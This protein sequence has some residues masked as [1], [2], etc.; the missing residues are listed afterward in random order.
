MNHVLEHAWPL[1]QTAYTPDCC[2][3]AGAILIDVFAAYQINASPLTVRASVYNPVATTHMLE[4]GHEFE[5]PEACAAV[6]GYGIGIGSMKNDVPNNP[7]WPY[8]LVVIGEFADGRALVD[9][10]L[11]QVNRP[12]YGIDLPSV[13]VRVNRAFLRGERAYS[14]IGM[15]HMITYTAMPEITSYRESPN[16]TMR[17]ERRPIT[18]Q[19]I[20]DIRRKL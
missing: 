20:T 3:V 8:H 1:L 2:I 7:M 12:E 6:G 17:R 16:W 4:M 15:G 11:P 18:D 9:L 14:F 19:L 5:S 13:A 10:T